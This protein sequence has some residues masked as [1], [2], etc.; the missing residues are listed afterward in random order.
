MVRRRGLAR[1]AART[2]VVA[3]TATS[4]SGRV[5]RSQ[6]QKFGAHPAPVPHTAHAAHDGG[7]DMVSKLQQ[8]ADLKA[9]GA[10]S[11]KE[12]ATAKAKLLAM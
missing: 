6:Q 3:G 12:F 9:A 11:D 5:A 8:L 1:T 4:V 10:L 2:A 7:G